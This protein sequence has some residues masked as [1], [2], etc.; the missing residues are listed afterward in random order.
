MIG[1]NSWKTYLKRMLVC[2]TYQRTYSASRAATYAE[3][4]GYPPTSLRHPV[5]YLSPDRTSGVNVE[6]RS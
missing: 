3:K 1:D 4:K 6:I 2:G 5:V